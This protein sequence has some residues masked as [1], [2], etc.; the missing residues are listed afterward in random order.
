[1]KSSSGHGFLVF[2][3]LIAAIGCAPEGVAPSAGQPPGWD[4]AIRLPAAADLNPDPGIV[5]LNLEA[6]AA[7]QS[8]RPGRA[9]ARC[10][11]TT[12]WFPGR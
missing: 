9:D 1:M 5:E 8:L 10:G 3:G 11:R 6:R 12:A 7:P 2:A 4:D